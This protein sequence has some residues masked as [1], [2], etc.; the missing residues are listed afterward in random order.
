MSPAVKPR[1]AAALEVTFLAAQCR[2]QP[3]AYLGHTQTS[4]V[5]GVALAVATSLPHFTRSHKTPF[6]AAKTLL[7]CTVAPIIYLLLPARNGGMTLVASSVHHF[8]L[9]QHPSRQ[10]SVHPWCVVPRDGAAEAGTT[11]TK[12]KG[13]LRE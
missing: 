13:H 10:H 4:L 8:P 11:D 5:E 1:L 7:V 2:L 6:R 9:G 12:Q 3:Q